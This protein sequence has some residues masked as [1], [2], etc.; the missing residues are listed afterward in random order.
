[1]LLSPNISWELHYGSDL[2]HY[3][4]CNVI[5]HTACH[6][7]V[8]FA[9]RPRAKLTDKLVQK[10]GIVAHMHSMHNLLI[11]LRGGPN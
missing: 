8:E 9:I 11:I 6:P 5:K 10:D 2:G 4:E 3:Y 1:M 7:K